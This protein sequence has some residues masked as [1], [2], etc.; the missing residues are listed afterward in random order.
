M[1]RVTEI[2]RSIQG[3]STPAG[4]PCTFVRLTGCP[5]RCV[6]C[7]SE[8]T[9][10]GGEHYSIDSIVDQVAAF[11]C[12]LVE[13]TG[14]EPLAQKQA[15]ELIR[16]LCDDEYEVLIETG[17]YVSTAA[18]DPRASVI[19]DIKCPASGEEPRNDWSNLERLRADKDEVKFVIAA[20]GDWIYAR[21]LIK[22]EALESRTKAILISPAWG[23]V[24]LQQ[25]AGWIAGSGL[26][27]R[28]QLQLHK[29]I[30]GPD[31]KGV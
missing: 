18:L 24:D 9:F 8:Y 20:E 2:F 16:R 28:M 22:K 31:V 27:I 4:R 13:V 5:M 23:Q 10:T 6:W 1:L 19:L 21:N 29:Y 25:L 26:N 17:G 11:G 30:W 12:R 7:D 14:G 15:F 3:E